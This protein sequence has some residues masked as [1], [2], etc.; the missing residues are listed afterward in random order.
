MNGSD[1]LPKKNTLAI[2]LVLT[3]LAL[4]AFFA[5]LSPWAHVF[6]DGTIYWYDPDCYVRVRKIWVLLEN[7]PKPYVFDYFQGY[8]QG[9]GVISTPLMEYVVAAL[10]FPF[11]QLAGFEPGLTVVIALIPVL[12]GTGGVLVFFAMARRWFGLIPASI[13]ALV[14]ALAAPYVDSTMLGRFDNEA[15]EAFLFL[16]S[17]CFY[18]K[19]YDHPQRLGPWLL[20]GLAAFIYLLVW[21]GALVPLSIIGVDILFR[22]WFSRQAILE[23][24]SIATRA[25]VLYLA[26]VGLTAIICLSDVWGTGKLF[27]YNIVSWFHVLL[28]GLAAAIPLLLGFF[29]DRSKTS[30]R[31]EKAGYT[32]LAAVALF[33]AW[34]LEQNIVSGIVMIG[35]GSAWIETIAQYQR[36]G[37]PVLFQ[38]YGPLVLLAPLALWFL[39]S[40]VFDHLACKRFFI[41]L[42]LTLLALSLF[43]LRFALYVGISAA[44][45]VAIVFR[46]VLAAGPLR[47]RLATLATPLV[48]VALLPNVAQL[49]YLYENPRSLV[50]NGDIGDAL[51]WLRTQTPPA[52]NPLRPD[53][54]PEYGVLSRWDYS[55]WIQTLALR[56]SVTTLFG[57]EAPGMEEAARFFLASDEAEMRRVL[58][59]NGVRFI[60]LDKM[61]GDLPMYARLIGETRPLLKPQWDSTHSREV[62]LPTAEAFGL[63]WSRLFFADG[64]TAST[65]SLTFKPVESVRLVYESPTAGK[66]ALLPWEVRKIKIFEYGQMARVTVRGTPGQVVSLVQPVET[67]QGRQFNYAVEK[68]IDAAGVATFTLPYPEKVSPRSTGSIGPAL[69][70][71]GLFRQEIPLDDLNQ[72]SHVIVLH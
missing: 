29:L 16:V 44:I 14:L 52:G 38:V 40:S 48:L 60:V 30:S 70:T 23:M 3:G 1:G 51:E 18:L 47:T 49:K 15:G 33:L 58:D 12:I 63:I 9:T 31:Q 65:D 53:Q 26:M 39:R 35:G 2:A 68:T 42:T 46:F 59:R 6:A 32:L 67:N 56:P 4:V 57:T 27:S 66:F 10:A 11:R 37:W 5:R 8:P 17:C 62:V 24:R 45:G 28:F 64:N 13:A 19:T 55:G 72:S 50:A 54:K 69:V 21:R 22:I 71:A 41:L 36:P 7:F 43:K 34:Q 20:A 61:M 25:G